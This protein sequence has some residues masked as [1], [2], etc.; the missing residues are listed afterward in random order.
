MNNHQSLFEKMENEFNQIC[1]CPNCG[2]EHKAFELNHYSVHK[3]VAEHG[4]LVSTLY[5]VCKKCADRHE[6][7]NSG[8][9]PGQTLIL[10]S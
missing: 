2:D 5:G 3:V 10:N 1:R 4:S 8:W 9:E 7:D 6:Y